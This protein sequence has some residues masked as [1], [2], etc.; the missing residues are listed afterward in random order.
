MNKSNQG[1]RLDELSDETH[2]II[3]E[4]GTATY[5][6]AD[7]EIPYKL[8]P[9]E[10]SNYADL[11]GRDGVFA[12]IDYSTNPP[13]IFYGKELT[14]ADMGLADKRSAEREQ[15]VAPTDAMGCPN[16]G[17]TLELKAPDKSER[18]TCPYCNSLL[19]INDGNLEYLKALKKK[20]PHSPF[21]LEVGMKGKFDNFV[22][23]V[24]LEI[25]GAMKR[26][27]VYDSIKYFWDEYLLYNPKVGFKWLVN[28]EKNWSFVES[29]NAADIDGSSNP[30]YKD[31]NFEKFASATATVEYVKGEFYWR[32]ETKERV[33]AT[34]FVSP[35][36]MLS[37]ES[38]DKEVNWSVGHF[39]ERNEIEKVFGVENL[40]RSYKTAPNQP[41]K[42]HSLIRSSLIVFIAF[43]L[44]TFILE[45]VK[46]SNSNNYV[47][48]KDGIVKAYG[49]N[50]LEN[51]NSKITFR[52]APFELNRDANISMR[53]ETH[54]EYES[55]SEFKLNLVPASSEKYDPNQLKGETLTSKVARNPKYTGKVWE[56]K[57]ERFDVAATGQ[58]QIE[59]EG[60]WKNWQKP[61]LINLEVRQY[62]KYEYNTFPTDGFILLFIFLAIPPVL[63]IGYRFVF[64]NK[65][66]LE[67]DFPQKSKIGIV[68]SDI[69]TGK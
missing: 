68:I 32:V 38:N 12:T 66:W 55:W 63:L 22:E 52:T 45:S 58:Y 1:Q 36:Y 25:I 56:I 29:V 49:L 44:A 41:F 18:V 11:V 28:S 31:N 48:Y 6:A 10:K 13:Y 50:P 57:Y 21:A 39:V 54:L 33:Q 20:V 40:P 35:P 42:Y 60:K 3:N 2:L 9:N 46:D 17:G 26:S 69:F 51:A 19:N 16:C 30:S 27:V 64:E 23:G 62:P 47:D 4:K 61:L 34:D 14:L 53:F 7:G 59:I 37:R 5:I 67:S 24:E 15:Q 43:L 65:R 8:N